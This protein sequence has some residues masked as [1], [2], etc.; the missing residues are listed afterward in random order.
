MA[1]E[2]MT[3]ENP[4]SFTAA[5]DLGVTRETMLQ[6][7]LLLRVSWNC[8]NISRYTPLENYS[9]SYKNGINSIADI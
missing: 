9:A 1:T 4:Y 8:Y 7:E 2:A 5:G 3:F 6:N